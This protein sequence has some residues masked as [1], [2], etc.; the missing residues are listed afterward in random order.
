MF[1]LPVGSI[2]PTRKPKGQKM[3]I[4]NDLKKEFVAELKDALQRR[5]SIQEVPYE[6]VRKSL[7]TRKKEKKG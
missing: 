5:V 7:S 4:K 1:I 6:E 2:L 3:N